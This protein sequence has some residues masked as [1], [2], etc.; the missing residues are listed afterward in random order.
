MDEFFVLKVALL[1]IVQGVALG[2]VVW[3]AWRI[4]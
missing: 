2:Y 3:T 1:V 4:E